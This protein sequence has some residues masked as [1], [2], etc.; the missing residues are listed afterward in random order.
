MEKRTNERMRVP[1]IEPELRM[2]I[3]KR[4]TTHSIGEG[5]LK[6]SQGFPN[7]CRMRRHTAATGE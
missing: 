5:F 1:S 6:R 3:V 2:N 7:R 4:I